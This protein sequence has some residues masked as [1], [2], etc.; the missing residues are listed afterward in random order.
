MVDMNLNLPAG[1]D[2]FWTADK[3]NEFYTTL[4]KIQNRCPGMS[5]FPQFDKLQAQKLM[6]KNNGAGCVLIMTNGALQGGVPKDRHSSGIYYGADYMDRDDYWAQK[7]DTEELATAQVAHMKGNLR[8]ASTNDRFSIMQWQSSPDI[9]SS[10]IFGLSGIAIEPTNPALYFSAVNAMGIDVWPTVILQ[11]YIGY[12]HINEGEFPNQLGSEIRV[13]CM[14]LNLYMVSQNC[15]ASKRKNPLLEKESSLKTGNASTA[16]GAD[17]AMSTF[18][19]IIYLNGTVDSDPPPPR[20]HLGRVE[21]FK[22]GTVFS[23]GTVLAVD[24]PNPNFDAET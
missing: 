16:F 3:A 1:K 21:V 11:D 17:I 9:L 19:G 15:R 12:I 22:A 14:G 13:L 8:D 5:S 24:T 18:N 6:D 2:R 20:F 4:E 23:N 10:G 7:V